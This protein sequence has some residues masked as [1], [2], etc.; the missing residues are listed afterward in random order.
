M[1]SPQLVKES[2]TVANKVAN[3]QPFF[4]TLV[5]F[6]GVPRKVTITVESVESA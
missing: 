4:W 5:D 3:K 6:G 2:E 1:R